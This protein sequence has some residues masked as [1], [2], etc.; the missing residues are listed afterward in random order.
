MDIYK[1]K[2]RYQYIIIMYYKSIFLRLAQKQNL[3]NLDSN[4]DRQNNLPS[5]ASD[6]AGLYILVSGGI[7]KMGQRICLVAP[8]TSPLEVVVRLGSTPFS[9]LRRCL[10]DEIMEVALSVEWWVC[11]LLKQGLGLGAVPHFPTWHAILHTTKQICSD[12]SLSWI[13]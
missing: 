11:Y 8:C 7:V 10:V 13:K 3:S 4:L 5:M 9:H 6:L 2:T 1:E 12:S